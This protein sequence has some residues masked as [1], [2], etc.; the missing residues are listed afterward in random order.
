MRN[1]KDVL[2]LC[3]HAVSDDW[4]DALAVRPVDLARQVAGLL[5]H[6]YVATTFTRASPHGMLCSLTAI[7][8][9]VRFADM[10]IA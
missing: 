1:A 6:G 5:E 2:V 3:Y 8:I 7:A 4:E 10:A 9:A